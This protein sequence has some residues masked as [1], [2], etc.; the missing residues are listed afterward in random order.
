MGGNTKGYR[1]RFGAV[2]RLSSGRYQARYPGPDDVLRNAPHTF[3]TKA[4]AER[5]LTLTEAE[6]TRREWLDPEA[7]NVPFCEYADAWVAERVLKAR[8]E[9]LYRNLLRVH[10]LPTF[11]E[12]KLGNIREAHV[13]RWRKARL[14]AGVG[15][16][17]VA[18]AYRLLRAILNTAV[19]DG[20]IRRNPC[21]IKGAGKEDSPE[22]PVVPVSTVLDLAD[23]VP[24]RYRI[25]VLLA[26]FAGLRWGELAG[27]RRR[28][29]DFDEG[30][31]K[32]AE[33]L[34][35][36]D[37]GQLVEEKP[38]SQAGRRTVAIPAMLLPELGWHLQRF[39][40]PGKDGLVFVGPKGG[41][42]RRSNFRATWTKARESVGL[43]DLH[44][45]DLRHT[46]N[47]MAAATGASLREL[48]ARM[49]HSSTRAALIYQ[50]ATTDRD[51][52]I[53]AGVEAL[54]AEEL[55]RREGSRDD[56]DD[57]SQAAGSDE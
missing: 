38:K 6:I 51:R 14:D 47:T 13:R 43:P 5:W 52:A 29:I 21:R 55:R 24:P 30:T 8:T 45:H 2:R 56:G 33:A 32:V 15:S 36:L 27:L 54:F 25:L 11:G 39:A 1:R 57:G 26:T 53:A 7:G 10:L 22:R 9:A 20:L 48:M 19:D 23:A 34:A 3:A 4:D 18:K 46:G 49:G 44:F 35:E 12:T 28:H 42:L 31:I 16:V 37:G 40:E 17:S 41:R 50:H